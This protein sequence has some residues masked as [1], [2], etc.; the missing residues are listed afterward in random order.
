MNC[1]YGC[2]GM[3]YPYLESSGQL[4]SFFPASLHKIKSHIFPKIS[5]FLIHRLRPFQ[6]KNNCELCDN[7]QDKDKRGEVMV[8]IYFVLRE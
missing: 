1:C 6:Y 7:I 4:D 5:K 2:P 8:K 3:N